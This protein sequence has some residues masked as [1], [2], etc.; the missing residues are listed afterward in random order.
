MNLIAVFLAI[1][2]FFKMNVIAKKSNINEAVTK[3]SLLLILSR[4]RFS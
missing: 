4:L 2:H 3:E 1:L